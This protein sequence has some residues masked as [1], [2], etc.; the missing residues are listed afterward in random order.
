MKISIIT[1]CYNSESTIEGTMQ[2]VLSQDYPFLEYIII[3]GES[4]DNTISII[5][6]YKQEYDENGFLSHIR[7]ISSAETKKHR[8]ILEDTEKILG[9]LHYQSK[10]HTILKSAYDLAINKSILEFIIIF[11]YQFSLI[12]F[13]SSRSLIKLYIL[14]HIY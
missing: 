11:L 1:P 13:D 10:M 12:C 3:D 9:N 2:S 4:I 7:I 14:V 8:Q 5:E 6:K